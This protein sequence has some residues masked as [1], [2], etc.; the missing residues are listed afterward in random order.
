MLFSLDPF[1]ILSIEKGALQLVAWIGSGFV[2]S[3]DL[4]FVVGMPGQFRLTSRTDFFPI[5][6]NAVCLYIYSSCRSVVAC[7]APS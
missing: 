4:V 3:F 2:I 5:S 1:E 7:I 6:N